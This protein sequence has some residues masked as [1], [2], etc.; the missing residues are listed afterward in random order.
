M[1]WV[2]IHGDKT[3][4]VDVEE[5]QMEVR[6]GMDAI[7]DSANKPLEINTVCGNMTGPDDTGGVYVIHCDNPIEARYLSLQITKT[8]SQ[9][10]RVLEIQ[11]DEGNLP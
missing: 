3:S 10:L 5:L 7:E 6:A 1:N 2:V 9:T 11:V 4:G 8:G